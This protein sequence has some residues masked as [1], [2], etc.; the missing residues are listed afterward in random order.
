MSILFLLYV[1]CFLLQESN[2][3]NGTEPAA[4]N[5][6]DQRRLVKKKQEVK[7]AKE[8]DHAEKRRAKEEKKKAAKEKEKE[9]DKDKE[10]EKEKGQSAPPPPPQPP[11]PPPHSDEKGIIQVTFFFFRIINKL[12]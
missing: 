5:A 7:E 6:V 4:S 8:R 3:C 2:C 12:I 1:F 10:K 9:K 11:A